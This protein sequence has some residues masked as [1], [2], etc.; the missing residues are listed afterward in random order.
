MMRIS[1]DK[2]GRL[3]RFFE[4]KVIKHDNDP[5]AIV[6]AE[7]KFTSKLG[8]IPVFLC[9]R[10]F[11]VGHEAYSLVLTLSQSLPWDKILIFL[12]LIPEQSYAIF[13]YT[14]WY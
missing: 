11:W 3:D 7:L 13:S 5:G 6:S 12:K 10:L 2:P 1:I 8:G 4:N 14:V 9:P